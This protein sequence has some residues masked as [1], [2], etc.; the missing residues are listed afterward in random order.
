LVFSPV[1]RPFWQIGAI[2]AA[3]IINLAVNSDKN[4]PIF[5]VADFGIV[6][7]LYDVIPKLIAQLKS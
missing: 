1:A 3:G 2:D 5:T 7:N 4:A 6:D